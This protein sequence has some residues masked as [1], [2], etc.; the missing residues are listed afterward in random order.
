[1]WVGHGLSSAQQRPDPGHRLLPL[2]LLPQPSLRVDETRVGSPRRSARGR[3]EAVP[4]GL[5]DGPASWTLLQHGEEIKSGI[6]GP[7]ELQVIPPRVFILFWA[8]IGAR[9]LGGAAGV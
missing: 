7:E 1:M 2:P 3:Q 4:D 5:P 8:R 9:W 6:L